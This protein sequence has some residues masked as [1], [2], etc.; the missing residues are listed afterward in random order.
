M[1][2]I[3]IFFQMAISPI[4]ATLVFSIGL[5]RQLNY[6]SKKTAAKIRMRKQKAKKMLSHARLQIF[7]NVITAQKNGSKM[8]LIIFCSNETVRQKLLFAK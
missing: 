3:E 6:P 1:N 7:V 2:K 5:K 4:L 8:R